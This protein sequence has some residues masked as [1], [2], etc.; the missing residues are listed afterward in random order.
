MLFEHIRGVTVPKLGFGTYELTGDRARESTRMALEVGYRHLDT[1]QMYENEFEI[2][3]A[4]AQSGVARE[5]LFITTKIWM[6]NAPPARTT[7][8]T[9]Q[10]LRQL[11]TDY[12]DLLLIHWPSEFSPA[13]TLHAMLE[14]RAA[15]KVRQIGVSNFP[16]GY[17]LELP[18]ELRAE[19]FCDQV[20]YHTFLSQDRLL[21][22]VREH[23]MLL[24]AYAPLVRGETA[25]NEV[26]TSI[27]AQ[28]G[29]TGAQ[30]ALRW[31]I[32][33]PRV[34][35]IPRAS[36]EKHARENFEIFDFALSNADRAAIAALPKDQRH[37][38][39]RW[40]PDWEA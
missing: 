28:Y 34:A 8:S 18:D 7:T 4:I 16:L 27:G 2:G 33:Q 24:T 36:S 13:A 14:L 21:T 19:L 22:Y 17:I 35:A 23:D 37:V 5:D 9:E 1:A 15:G 26:L 29:K 39:P 25:K 30:V 38:R 6:T 20:E 40:A 11:Q 31:L 12:L 3:T 10:S 32:E